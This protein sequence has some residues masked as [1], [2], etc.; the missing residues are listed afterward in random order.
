MKHHPTPA[1]LANIPE[2]TIR[3]WPRIPL[4]IG[5]QPDG[6]DRRGRLQ[7]HVIGCRINGG[8]LPP[9]RCRRCRQTLET[10]YESLLRRLDKYARGR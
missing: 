6:I 3:T 1:A 5:T 8:P 10:D 7:H 9:W 2:K 4:P